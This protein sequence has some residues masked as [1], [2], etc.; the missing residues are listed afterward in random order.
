MDRREGG[1]GIAAGTCGGEP[2]ADRGGKLVRR[3]EDGGKERDWLKGGAIQQA[4]S[5]NA[6]YM[7][8]AAVNR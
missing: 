3:R 2:H 8:S 6:V 5:G 4:P 1:E 7:M